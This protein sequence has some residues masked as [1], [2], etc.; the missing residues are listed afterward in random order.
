MDINFWNFDPRII[1]ESKAEVALLMFATDP[2]V[3]AS[4]VKFS[5][6]SEYLSRSV[7]AIYINSFRM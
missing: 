5:T 1:E 6:V 3:I 7:C 2:K 4:P